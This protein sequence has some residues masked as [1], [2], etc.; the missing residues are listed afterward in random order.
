MKLTP[1]ILEEARELIARSA[2]GVLA[3]LS[4]QLEG[5]PF[6]SVASFCLDK[7]GQPLIYMSTIAQHT[8]NVTADPR[9]SLIALEG[10]GKDVQA[11]GRVTIIGQLVKV[12]DEALLERYHRYF[13]AS[14]QY[15]EFHDFDLYRLEPSKVRY[16]GGFGRIFWIEP[17]QIFQADPITLET[18]SFIVEHMNDHHQH[19]LVDY[20]R[21]YAGQAAGEKVEMAGV[22]TRAMDI[23]NEEHR[24]RVAL[25]RP[26]HDGTEAR[27]VMVEMAKEAQATVPS[28]D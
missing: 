6:A 22:D 2:H 10:P 24:V 11:E 20:I 7:Q 4:L 15:K 17:Q 14:R 12:E 27:E 23:L 18:E 9:C 16:I 26:I 3:T 13:P 28:K 8:L 25:S 1:E 5:A 21:H 19:N